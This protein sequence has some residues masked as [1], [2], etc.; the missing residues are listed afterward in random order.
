MLRRHVL[1]W[2]YRFFI[3]YLVSHV[4]SLQ[5]WPRKGLRRPRRRATRTASWEGLNSRS[6]TRSNGPRVPFP[7]V[8][9]DHETEYSIYS[10]HRGAASC[11]PCTNSSLNI[12][13]ITIIYCIYIIYTNIINQISLI[14]SYYIYSTKNIYKPNLIPR[15][16]QVQCCHVHKL[17]ISWCIAA[18]ARTAMDCCSLVTPWEEVSLNSLEAWKGNLA[19][20]RWM[21]CFCH[22][23]G[24]A[25]FV[26]GFC[27]DCISDESLDWG[28]GPFNMAK[29]IQRAQ[30]GHDKR[31]HCTQRLSF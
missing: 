16:Q 19:Q 8:K 5:F 27:K 22:T 25:T 31:K 28:K 4:L 17:S 12:L 26:S 18:V 1:Y 30:D 29:Q 15:L 7:K 2:L 6:Q 14:N 23:N 3:I 11:D 10:F 13:Y 21:D 9:C 24:F 20:N